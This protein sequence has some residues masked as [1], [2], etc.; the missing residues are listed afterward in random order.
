MGLRPA[1]RFAPR[2][3]PTKEPPNLTTHGEVSMQVRGSESEVS[4]RSCE[5]SQGDRPARRFA[6]RRLPTN[7]PP[8]LTT[9]G[10]SQRME[11]L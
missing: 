2:R 7:E 9:Q 3:L 4:A 6:P 1:R 10:S 5:E 8:N 11:F